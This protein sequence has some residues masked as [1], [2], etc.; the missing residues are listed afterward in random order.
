MHTFTVSSELSIAPSEFWA[1]MS[2]SAVNAE[3]LP[4]VR[5]T[6]P[7]EWQHCSLERWATGKVLFRS[8]VLFLGFLPVDVH[9]MRLEHISPGSGFLERSHSWANRLWQHERTTTATAKGC[10]VT[11][12]VSVEGR[13]PL[14]TA[15]LL[16]VYRLVFRH[17]HNRLKV[18]Y[19][20]PGG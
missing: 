16:P 11:D 7:S 20:Q 8:V 1:R 2:M 5:M 14:F 19:G 10:V 9:S 18:R 15:L 6:S 12:T 17:R 3:L 13:V 4:L